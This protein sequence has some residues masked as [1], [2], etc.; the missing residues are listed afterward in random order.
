MNALRRGGRRAWTL[1]RMS[2]GLPL[3]RPE[4]RTAQ[5]PGAYGS[6][7]LPGSPGR[8]ALC[9]AYAALAVA[10]L[11][12]L[13]CGRFARH[14]SVGGIVLPVDGVTRVVAGSAGLVAALAV[15][16]G[17]QVA[18][19]QPLAFMRG[20]RTDGR[21]GSA[22][23]AQRALLLERRSSL[24]AELVQQQR[25]AAAR[26]TA[27]RRV[28]A[29]HRATLMQSEAAVH[30]QERREQLAAD[31]L[32]R[33]RQLAAAG[34]VAGL[35]VSEREADWLDQRQRLGDLQR[36]VLETQRQLQ[37][38]RTEQSELQ[39]QAERDATTLARNLVTL[40]QELADV[41]AREAWTVVAPSA[42]QVSAISVRP[43]QVASAGQVLLALIDPASA[44]E[45]ELYAPPSAAGL[46]RVGQPVSLRFQAFP[47]QQYGQ[48]H[49]TVRG[50]SGHAL[51]AGELEPEAATLL[52]RSAGPFYR[53]Q[54]ALQRQSVRGRSGPLRLQPGT[55]V[56]ASIRL[57]SRR[58][59]QW[60]LAPL[61]GLAGGA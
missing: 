12:F 18:A 24:Q 28:V 47:Y 8:A 38:A 21:G 50:I 27:A 20:V 23:A 16:E 6:I 17:Q 61:S 11:V 39:L 10:G 56:D 37:A 45:A 59:Y 52:A 42:G 46:L 48:Y 44:L 25:Q 15:R 26:L 49:G 57:E 43:G 60:M 51:Q 5:A 32:Q 13:G 7:L 55:L 9:A 4:V 3:F 33:Y 34:H 58:L 30:W 31:T 1:P 53:V 29:E 41:A 54:V 40:D 22:E 2:T 14:A 36:A 19:G 35:A